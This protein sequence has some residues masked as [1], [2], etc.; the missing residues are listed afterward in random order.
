MDLGRI[1]FAIRYSI[2]FHWRAG[3]F[4]SLFAIHPIANSEW[5]DWVAAIRYSLFIE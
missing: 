5:N 4:H 3:G 2:Q 1:P